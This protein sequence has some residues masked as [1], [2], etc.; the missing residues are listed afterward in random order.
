M[1]VSRRNVSRCVDETE[2]AA[3]DRARVRPDLLEGVLD[4]EQVGEVAIGVDADR[5][6][7]GLVGVVEDRQLFVEAIAD[8]ALA[9]DRLLRVD[10]HGA[11]PGNE[12]EARLEVLEVIRRQR[13]ESL[14]VDR[15]DPGREEPRVE[16]EQAG[17]VGRGRFDVAAYVAHDEGVAVEDA[18]VVRHG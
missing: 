8:G 9:D 1:T 18:D 13:V 16:R 14:A 5:E 6:V 7:D 3:L 12:E 2:L 17:R 4:L 10:V 15:Q 11:R